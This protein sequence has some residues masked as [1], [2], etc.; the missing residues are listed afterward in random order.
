MYVE[1]EQVIN[2]LRTA[3]P[4]R[5]VVGVITP[6]E[7]KECDAIRTRLAGKSWDDIPD[8]FA[9]E[10]SGSLPLLSLDAYNAFLPIWLRAAVNNPNGEAANMVVIN[11][12]SKP[13]HYGFT[14]VQANTI[15]AACEFIVSNNYWAGIDPDD[16]A[17]TIAR[18]KSEW[19]N[20]VA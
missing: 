3:F 20:G 17:A 16:S 2:E 19:C 7:C 13:S 1:V 4:Q 8:E 11:L 14:S 12:S 18:I 10:F 5:V 6:H 9:E 15:I